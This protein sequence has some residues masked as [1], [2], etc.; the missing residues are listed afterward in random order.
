MPSRRGS[1]RA[2]GG[3]IGHPAEP[4]ERPVAQQ[5]RADH[6][7]LD[8]HH[9]ATGVTEVGSRVGGVGAVVAHHEELARGDDDIEGC[10]R[11]A[12]PLDQ[13]G[14]VDG[15]AIDREQT[16]LITAHDPVA[17]HP[18]HALD[19]VL[20]TRV[21]AKDA[22]H[23]GGDLPEGSA[24]TGVRAAAEGVGAVEDDDVAALDVAAELGDHHAIADRPGSGSSTRRG[25][26]R[27]AT[28]KLRSTAT[29]TSARIR[30]TQTG[31]GFCGA[32]RGTASSSR[33]GGARDRRQRGSDVIGEAA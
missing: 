14:L 7:G 26:R 17:T 9:A 13:I 10:L 32:R 8:G 16:A 21:D 4:A 6:V 23:R 20:L 25:H 1:A 2:T 31:Q 19:I 12:H 11:G 3:D 29:R 18:D 22:S 5:G 28:T 24:P 27:T 15:L 30:W 33:L